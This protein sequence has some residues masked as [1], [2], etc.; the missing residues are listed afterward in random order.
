MPRKTLHKLLPNIN[1]VL[2]RSKVKWLKSLA[3][4]PNLLQINRHSVSIA[5]FIGIFTAFIPIPGQ[6]IVVFAMSFWIRANLPI[7]VAIVWLSNPVTIPPIFYLT[8]QLGS[9][10]TGA[11]P[12][13]FRITT[14]WEWFF[15][16]GVKIL[17]P[18][19]IGGTI[20]G[21]I[22]GTLGYFFVLRFWRFKVI[23]NW[24]RRSI[25]RRTTKKNNTT[26]N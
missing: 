23:K 26:T 24:Q 20:I 25:Q 10:L 18:L 5:V 1:E 7:A 6:T 21:L 22:C 19:M 14:S 12:I 9:F 16:V 8:Y 2:K 11:E 3:S 4:D 13:D 17:V 15:T